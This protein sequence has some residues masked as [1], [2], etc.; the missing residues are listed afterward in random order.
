MLLFSSRFVSLAFRFILSP[1]ATC[2]GYLAAVLAFVKVSSA[3]A[4][5]FGTADRSAPAV[6]LPCV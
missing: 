3:F 2:V 5:S 6:Y 4:S 1:V